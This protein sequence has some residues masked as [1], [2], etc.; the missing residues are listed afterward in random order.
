[1]LNL[2]RECAPWLN[3]KIGA[4]FAA[5]VLVAGLAFGAQAGLLAFIS[6]TPVLAIAACMVP[7]LLP[8]V[9]LRNGFSRSLQDSPLDFM[10]ALSATLQ[11]TNIRIWLVTCS[12]KGF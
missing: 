1:M 2:I 11:R 7:C 5:V 9:F 4:L 6:A 8:V 10:R 3:W 12:L